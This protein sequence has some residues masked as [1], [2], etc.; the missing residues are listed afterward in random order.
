MHCSNDRIK[1]LNYFSQRSWRRNFFL[2]DSR[3]Q[4]KRKNDCFLEGVLNNVYYA[5]NPMFRKLNHADR[6]AIEFLSSFFEYKAIS[7]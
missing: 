7:L 3:T 1:S 6:D 4:S 5:T 2:I